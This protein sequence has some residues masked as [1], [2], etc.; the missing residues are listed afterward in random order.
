MKKYSLFF[1]V[2]LIGLSGFSQRFKVETTNSSAFYKKHYSHSIE[3]GFVNGQSRQIVAGNETDWLTNNHHIKGQSINGTTF[4]GGRDFEVTLTENIQLT[5]F[6]IYP[7]NNSRFGAGT[8]IYYPNGVNGMGYPYLAIYDKSSMTVTSSY[9]YNVVYQSAGIE[10]PSDAIGL[11]II[12]CQEMEA[13]YIS[14]TMVDRNFADIDMN[15]IVAKM[16]GFIMKIDANNLSSANLLVIQP[17]NLPTAPDDPMLCSVHDLEL[18]KDGKFIA[19]TGI[20]TKNGIPGGYYHP[21]VGMI[22]TQLNVQWSNV[23][24]FDTDHYSGVDVEYNTDKGTLLVLMNSSR[25]P[26]AVMELDNVGNVLQSPVKYEFYQPGGSIPMLLGIARAHKMHYRNGAVTITGNCFVRGATTSGD[27]LLFK[28]EIADALDLNNGDGFY[29]SYSREVVPLGNQKIVTGYWAPENSIYSDDN[30]FIVGIYNNSVSFGYT[31]INVNGFLNQT[32]CL[33]KG[34]VKMYQFDTNPFEIPTYMSHCDGYPFGID[35]VADNPQPIEEC[36]TGK[37]ETKSYS[38]GLDKS[39]M[40]HLWQFKGIDAIGIHAILFSESNNTH[41]DVV[42]YDV[43]GRKI[44][45]SS[46]NVNG[47]QQEICLEFDVKDEMY[48]IKVSN[49]SQSKTLKVAGNR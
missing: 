25:N 3:E 14:G 7:T 48:I 35:N 5:D 6:T 41:Y 33:E 9:W 32:G 2:I 44:A 45:S 13:F 36:P 1:L 34:E 11:K 8:G 26:F 18:S 31:M 29:N 49:G 38:I 17:D 47:G 4:L 43:M 37:S 12:Y 20:T 24:Q 30:L 42:V 46:Y 21:M 15:N 39:G 10:V 28:Y 23:Y 22:N 16:R 27:Q 19:F 40:D